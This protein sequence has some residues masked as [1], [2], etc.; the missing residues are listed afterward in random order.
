MVRLLCP[1]SPSLLIV[2]P[3][4]PIQFVGGVASVSAGRVDSL[5]PYMSAH[6]VIVDGPASSTGDTPGPEPEP[7]P[8][9]TAPV[10]KRAPKSASPF[11]N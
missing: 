6:G 3:A 7:K 2:D 4:G 1:S 10:R 8:E 9:A 5:A 11:G